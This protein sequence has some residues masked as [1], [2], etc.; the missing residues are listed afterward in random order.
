MF[1][2]PL[3]VFLMHFLYECPKTFTFNLE[4]ELICNSCPTN[5]LFFKAHA[6]KELSV[7]L[8]GVFYCLKISLD[9]FGL[10]TT[11]TSSTH[12]GYTAKIGDIVVWVKVGLRITSSWLCSWDLF[13]RN[14]V[15]TRMV[16]YFYYTLSFTKFQTKPFNILIWF[17]FI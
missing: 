5:P 6:F 12:A 17:A 7:A 13:R 11:S 3:P 4:N 10:S 1:L 9:D 14:F 16:S 15:W 8:V 2:V